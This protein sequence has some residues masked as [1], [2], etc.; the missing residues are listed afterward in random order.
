ML[1]M[2]IHIMPPMFTGLFVK[3]ILISQSIFIVYQ[4]DQRRSGKKSWITS[5]NDSLIYGQIGYYYAIN[6]GCNSLWLLLFE[7]SHLLAFALISVMTFTSV[8]I[9]IF[10]I[11][12]ATNKYE[13]VL[14]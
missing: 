10:S 11:G 13:K 3:A 8:K 12:A 9:F 4:A 14:V 1:K 2:D 6:L 7:T 5:R